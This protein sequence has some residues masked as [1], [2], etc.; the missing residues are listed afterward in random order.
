MNSPCFDLTS[1]MRADTAACHERAVRRVI[2]TMRERLDEELS[3]KEMA[4]VAIMSPFHFNRT[5]HHVVGMPPRRFLSALRVER[6]RHLLLTTEERVTDVCFEVGYNSL[7]TFTR[8]FTETFGL[9]PRALRRCTMWN[10]PPDVQSAARRPSSRPTG[11]VSGTIVAPDDF[12]GQ[13]FVGLFATP[14]PQG[15]P[16]SCCVAYGSETF[17][18]RAPAGRWHLYA[19]GVRTPAA[20]LDLLLFDDALRAS[21]GVIDVPSSHAHGSARLE[22]RPRVEFDPPILLALPALMT[23]GQSRI[24]RGPNRRISEAVA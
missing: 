8:R 10:T 20:P 7:G 21:G 4:D 18:L 2:T 9:S 5:F 12:L 22:L 13:V 23:G 11:N 17:S 3:L 1:R 16:V 14:I 15:M 24:N 6:A 19:L